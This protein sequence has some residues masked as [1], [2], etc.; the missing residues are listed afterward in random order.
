MK[1]SKSPLDKNTFVTVGFVIFNKKTKISNIV[2]KLIKLLQKNYLFF[3]IMIIDNGST[4][5]TND[6][7]ET[8]M[9]QY[10]NIRYIVLSKH[11]DIEVAYSAALENSLGD[12]IVL[13]DVIHDPIDTIPQI[14]SKAKSGFDIV[15]G[16]SQKRPNETIIRKLFAYI[17]YK[18]SSY[19][20][21]FKISPF[22]TYYRV[23]S[24]NAVNS[25]CRLKDKSRY[26]KYFSALVGYK[27]TVFKYKQINYKEKFDHKRSLLKSIFFATEIIVSNS[28]IPLRIASFLGLIAS[29][30]NLIFLLYIFFITLLK[31][32][33]AVGWISSTVVNS[34]MFF[35]IF[36]ILTIISEYIARIL[37][38]SK[39]QPLY[40]IAHENN[41]SM[42]NTIKRKKNVE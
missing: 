34:T 23:F 6:A 21:D 8:L 7:V 38:Q 28:I 19:I 14:V 31:D 35:L 15:I 1:S 3:E 33:I 24:R 10:P 9:K 29:F 4:D 27:Q 41:S 37:N 42:L 16:E 11:Y 2:N 20:L 40:F 5:N 12:Y 26:I 13:F 18:I 22:T 32:R 36:L 30:L 39:D 17:F 25:I